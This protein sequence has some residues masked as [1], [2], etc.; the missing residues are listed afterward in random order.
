MPDLSQL[1]DIHLP[2][3]ISEW[4][5]AYGWWL[6]SILLITLIAVSV[7]LYV[8]YRKQY[9]VQ[10]AALTLLDEEYENYKT[11]N[12]SQVFLHQCNQIL[13][14]YCLTHYPEAISLSG[15]AWSH[16]LISY[17]NKAVFS[18][19][20][21]AAIS[22]GLYQAHC[23]YNVD[24]LYRVCAIWLKSNKAPIIDPQAVLS[25]AELS[26]AESSKAEP[27]PTDATHRT[28]K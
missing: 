28:F 8:Q 26:L 3:S 14:R 24:E 23:Q 1:K 6:V 12:D 13:K 19:D 25:Q 16:F 4:P 2:P 10:R 17:C 9:A 20:L 27:L 15:Q 21:T 11:H 5:L 7:F 22:E 18:S